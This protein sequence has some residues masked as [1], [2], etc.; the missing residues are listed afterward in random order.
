MDLDE[1]FDQ[2]SDIQPHWMAAYPCLKKELMVDHNVMRWLNIIIL[3]NL[4]LSAS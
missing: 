4:H 1:R 2:N 3:T